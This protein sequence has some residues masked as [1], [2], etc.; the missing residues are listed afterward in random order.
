M[1]GLFAL[2]FLVAFP[3]IAQS[4]PWMRGGY[5]ALAAASLADIELTGRAIERGLEE[6]NPLYKPFVQQ[7]G[8]LGLVNGAVS[9]VVGVGAYKL[10]KKGKRTEA[11]IL[12]WGWTALRAAVVIHNVRVLRR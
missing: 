11:R 2:V 4:D 12:I 3:A 7:P 10:H 6:K 5:V 1:K 8:L 9:G